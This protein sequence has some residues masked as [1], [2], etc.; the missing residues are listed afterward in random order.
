MRQ[1]S[2]DCTEWKKSRF[3]LSSRNLRIV[4]NA[5]PTGG[6]KAWDNAAFGVQPQGY[7]VANRMA[8]N[9]RVVADLASFTRKLYPL[10]LKTLSVWPY[11]GRRPPPQASAHAIVV[12]SPH[13]WARR[14]PPAEPSGYCR[15]EPSH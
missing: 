15:W 9:A 10:R 14:R 6:I 1:S 8:G 2:S 7:G 5:N 3:A 12:T 4:S 11:R 13:N